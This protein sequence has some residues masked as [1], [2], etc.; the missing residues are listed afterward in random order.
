MV[1]ELRPRGIGEMLDA[2]ISLYR[3]RFRRV[4]L[5]SLLV[6]VPIEALIVLLLISAE[7][8]TRVSVDQSGTFQVTTQSQN[9]Q[10]GAGFGAILLF[11]VGSLTVAALVARSLAD[12]YVGI[13]AQPEPERRRPL[14]VIG[15]LVILTVLIGIGLVVCLIPGLLLFTAWSVAIPALILEGGSAFHALKRSQRL[16]SSRYLATMGL[17][18]TAWLLSSMLNYAISL[19]ANLLVLHG[20]SRTSALLAQGTA[21]AI[22]LSVTEP[23]LAAALVACYFDLRIRSEAFDVQLMLQR[24]DQRYAL[25]S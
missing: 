2:A 6:V 1:P 3:A 10:L 5:T 8:T 17:V 18:A 24:S 14:T 13:D 16:V 11:I 22:V 21:S 9:A 25:A 7:P 20:T 19:G 15:L 4:F 23:V 12:A